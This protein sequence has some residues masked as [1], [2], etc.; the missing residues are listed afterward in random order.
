MGCFGLTTLRD[1]QS[2]SSDVAASTP[3]TDHLIW[4]LGF[5][6]VADFFAVF[7]VGLLMVLVYS[8]RERRTGLDESGES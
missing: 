4:I 5:V 1:S 8:A 2:S 6:C 3:F 7:L